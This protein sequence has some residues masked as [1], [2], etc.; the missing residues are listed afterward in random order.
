MN[1][2]S[3]GRISRLLLALLMAGSLLVAQGTTP[4]KTPDTVKIDPNEL[5]GKLELKAAA[6]DLSTP[7]IAQETV[8]AFYDYILSP[9][10]M[11]HMIE[12]RSTPQLKAQ[13]VNLEIAYWQNTN[14]GVTEQNIFD[15]FNN[16]V[17][18]LSLH[19]E[20]LTTMSQVR[21]T[22]LMLAHI[23]PV[24][25]GTRLA[26]KDAAGNRSINPAM[27]PLQAAMVFDTLVAAKF[28]F[29]EFYVKPEDWEATHSAQLHPGIPQG[30][31]RPNPRFAPEQEASIKEQRAAVDKLSDADKAALWSS[32]LKYFGVN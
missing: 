29:K 6:I 7:Q 10:S 32:T 30:L 25:I 17:T 1:H 13:V 16:A 24:T 19:R 22:R 21:E 12:I 3:K 4:F 31:F 11:N 23:L 5:G 28:T 14:P 26:T 15:A 18:T 2:Y 9:V 20:Y 8:G 27:S